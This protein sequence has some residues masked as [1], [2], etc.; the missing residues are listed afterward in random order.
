MHKEKS[1]ACTRRLADLRSGVT[2]DFGS[3]HD[4]PFVLHRARP[5]HHD[6]SDPPIRTSPISTIVR[7]HI[8]VLTTLSKQENVPFQCESTDLSSF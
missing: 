4:L 3:F 7:E 5:G 1:V 8:G 6:N 2:N